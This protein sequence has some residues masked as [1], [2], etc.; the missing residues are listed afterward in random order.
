VAKAVQGQLRTSSTQVDVL[1]RGGQYGKAAA[2]LDAKLKNNDR[3]HAAW[4]QLARVENHRR[5]FRFALAAITHALA[6]DGGRVIYQRLK[7]I[8]LSNQR[9]NAEAIR[10]LA[11]VV[12][13][14]P[15]DLN[16]LNA[17]QT[18]HYHAGNLD[19]AVS[20]GTLIL[21]LQDRTARPVPDPRPPKHGSVAPIKPKKRMIAFSLW[22][23]Q[24]S[25]NH[26]AMVNARL[27]RFIYP[28]WTCR[29]YLGADVPRATAI[30]LKQAGAEIVN[31]E[32]NFREIPKACWRFLVADDSEVDLFLCR[33]CDARLTPKEAVAVD[34]W[35]RSGRSFHVMRDN[36]LHRSLILAGLW[37]GQ[38]N[39]R[40]QIARRIRRY[41]LHGTDQRY[42]ADQGFLA[43][44][45]W[46]VIRDDVLIHDSYYTLFDAQP[47]PGFGK[48]ID[49]DHVGM[50]IIRANVLREEAAL[51]G[52]P[53][54]NVR[55][56]R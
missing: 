7:G 56:R 52:L 54:A 33:D 35:L 22:G 37:G 28:G 55:N 40:L 20:L 11:A 9:A 16:A 5:R 12:E 45:I 49:R 19:K 1:I 50:G 47:F 53:W 3:N 46:P 39:I 24:P 51:L 23:A 41:F 13:C 34:A 4:Y 31:A 42:G 17:L 32:A 21:E 38:T 18:A 8:I 25:Y 6:I 14:R 10:I 15:D 36:V 29:F 30:V 48:G 43:N 26:G 44:E 27:A 2:Y